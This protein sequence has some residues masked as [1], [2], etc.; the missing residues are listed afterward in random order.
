MIGDNAKKVIFFCSALIGVV[1]AVAVL[2][3]SVKSQ[4]TYECQI[5]SQQ[6]QNYRDFY[7]TTWQAEQ[8][9]ARGIEVQAKTVFTPR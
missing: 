3:Y 7:L 2:R 9:K 5:W 8:C 4:E 1:L 6:A